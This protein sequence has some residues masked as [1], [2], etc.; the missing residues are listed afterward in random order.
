MGSAQPTKV[1]TGPLRVERQPNGDR[2]LLNDLGVLVDTRFTG[3]VNVS[4]GTGSLQCQGKAGTKIT[5]YYTFISDYS[6]IPTPFQWVVHW[7]KVD[8]AGVIHDFLYRNTDCSRT[9]ADRVWWKLARAGG[10]RADPLQAWLCWLM[11]WLVGG[12]C[13]PTVREGLGRRLIG[14]AGAALLV[15]T[16]PPVAV[17]QTCYWGVRL[18]RRFC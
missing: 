18:V 4:P 8:I 16:T 17:W 6:S 12:W 1:V 7:S 9:E 3:K 13:R 2:K 14:A 5:V 11:L 10:H 15:T